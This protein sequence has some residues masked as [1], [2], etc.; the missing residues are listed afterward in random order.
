M[1][2]KEKVI[3]LEKALSFVKSNDQIVTGLG[4]E[5]AQA[6]MDG[7]PTIANRVKNV[8]ITNCLPLGKCEYLKREYRHSFNCDGWFYS[9]LLRKAHPNGNV[10]FIPNHLHFAGP[11]RLEHIPHPDIFVAVCSKPDKHGYV[12]LSLSN[13]YEKRCLDAA[14]L[15]ILEVNP[16]YPRAFGDCEVHINDV[17]YFVEVNYPIPVVPEGV[18]SE[19]DKIIGDL[20]AKEIRDGDCIQIGIGGI[21]NALCASLGNKKHLGIHTELLTTGMMKLIKAGVIDNSCKQIQKGKSV[22]TMIMGTPE[23]YEFVDDNPTVAVMDGSYVNNPYVIAQND[24]QVSINTALEVDLTGQVCSESI[25]SVQFSGA[26]GQADTAIGAQLSKGGRSFIC[27]YSTA[28]VKNPATGEKEEV[29]K[30]VAQLKAGA[31]VTLQRQDVQFIVTE[32][33]I[34]DLHGLNVR[35]RV[36]ALIKIAHP[37]FR[38]QLKKD[39]IACGIIGNIDDED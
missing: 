19:K 17:D 16:N 11:R 27:L 33:G 38:E 9:P 25:G 34:A 29:S 21:P 39:A 3:S 36:A 35:E 6:F 14:K 8:T 23:L 31:I 24:N 15:V 37:K 4:C 5:E 32:Y 13:T 26:G 20:I 1:D 28:F 30:I 12:S 7:L 2:Y 22:T 10:S 18:F